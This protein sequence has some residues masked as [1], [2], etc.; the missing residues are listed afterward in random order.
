M[1]VS[2]RKFAGILLVAILSSV[3]VVAAEGE[4]PSGVVNVNTASVE[5]LTLLPRIGPSSAA[6]II[7]YRSA[8][9]GFKKVTD[10]LQVKGIGPSTFELIKPWVAI[11]GDTTLTSKVSTSASSASE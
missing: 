10:L 5:Q 9:G 7:E 3:A 4:N 2:I 8:N 1:N 11:E 6:Q